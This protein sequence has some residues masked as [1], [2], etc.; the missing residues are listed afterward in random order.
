MAADKLYG[1]HDDDILVGGRTAY[2]LA[3]EANDQALLA[4]MTEW[5]DPTQAAAR[6]ANIRSG[7]AVGAAL[8]EPE[9]VFADLVVDRIVGALGN[10]W[11]L[12]EAREQSDRDS[13]RADLIDRI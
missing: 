11:F 4:I 1:G 7:L 9:F 5:R 13:A 2:D 8:R 6:R 10:D 3:T 12:L